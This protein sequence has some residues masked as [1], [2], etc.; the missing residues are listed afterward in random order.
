MGDVRAII[1]DI[2]GTTTPL[3]FVSETLFPYARQ[4]LRVFLESHGTTPEGLALQA[5][6]RQSHAAEARDA[7]D[8]PPWIE[9]TPEARIDSIVGYVSWLMDRDRKSTP[10]KDL[11]GRIWEEGYRAG[12]LVGEVFADVP[13]ALERWRNQRVQVGIFSSGSVLAQRLLFRHSSAGDLTSFLR[14]HFDTMTGP[15]TDVES[16]SRIAASTG[17]PAPAILFVSDVVRELDAATRAGM[18]T[19]LSRRPGNTPAPGDHGHVAVDTF[20]DLFAARS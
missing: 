11:Q 7:V 16:Y 8:L 14:W 6:L 1:L 19:A 2:E 12:E 9:V 20:D 3:S 10:L 17:V 4:K 15:K 18:Q 5:R 13:P